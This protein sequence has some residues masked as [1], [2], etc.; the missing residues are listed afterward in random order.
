ML[1]SM[2]AHVEAMLALKARG[3]IAFDYGNNL[4]G[5]VADLRGM[6]EAFDI[7]GFRA[8]VHPPAVL[9]RRRARSAGRRSPAIRGTS[10]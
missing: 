3:A 7:P 4:R 9:P 5:Q 1:D 6:S 10:R 8:R 2:C